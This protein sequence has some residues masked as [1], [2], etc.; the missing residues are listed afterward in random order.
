MA[1]VSRGRFAS[2]RVSRTPP[3]SDGHQPGLCMGRT[4]PRR[5]VVGLTCFAC[6]G[7][8]SCDRSVPSSGDTGHLLEQRRPLEVGSDSVFARQA[9]WVVGSH[10]G[11]DVLYD[12]TDA[13][14]ISDSSILV[15]SS[16]GGYLHR[17]D[18]GRPEPHVLFG[19]GEG[20]TE[21]LEPGSFWRGMGDSLYLYDRG[22]RRALW[23]TADGRILRSETIRDGLFSTVWPTTAGDSTRFVGTRFTQIA[24]GQGRSGPAWIPVVV[25]AIRGERADSIF[26]APVR[27]VFFTDGGGFVIPPLERR[28][29]I[30]PTSRGFWYLPPEGPEAQHL[31][32]DGDL[33]LLVRWGDGDLEIDQATSRAIAEELAKADPGRSE[34]VRRSFEVTDYPA[35]VPSF[36]SAHLDPHERLWVVR[37]HYA[38]GFRRFADVLSRKTGWLRRVPLPSEGRVLDVGSET[39]VTLV[40]DA[41]GVEYLQV[42]FLA[43]PL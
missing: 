33:Q 16:Q 5:V 20:P 36:E 43:N 10:G 40:H 1:H 39:L 28:G 11:F 6:V 9:G 35:R 7:A 29:A 12:V 26:S 3:R 37:R 34:R 2:Q 13:I 32:S 38:E 18:R 17:Y 21:I 14:P 15:S 8:S 23:I 27:H 22:N 24:P 4:L 25:S 41:L 19:K 42:H 31:N 30:V